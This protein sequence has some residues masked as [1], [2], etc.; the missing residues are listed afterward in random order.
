MTKHED[1][2]TA[3]APNPEEER[4]EMIARLRGKL[5]GLNAARKIAGLTDEQLNRI[6]MMLSETLDHLARTHQ[7]AKP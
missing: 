5:S 1:V 7:R 6:D 2:C 4:Q 3:P